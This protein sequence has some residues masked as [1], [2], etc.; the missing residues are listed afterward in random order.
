MGAMQYSVQHVELSDEEIVYYLRTAGDL[1]VEEPKH[2]LIDLFAG[3]GGLSL[4]FSGVFGHAFVPVWAND[5]NADAARTYNANFGH[6]CAVGDISSLL[7]NARPTIPQ[8]DVVI[9]GPRVRA[10]ACSTSSGSA[11][12]AG[13]CGGRFCRWL[14]LLRRTSS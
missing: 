1:L 11:T 5:F 8:A 10:S 7:E 13:S 12:L 3:A 6:A 14:S 4:G 9:G 2:G